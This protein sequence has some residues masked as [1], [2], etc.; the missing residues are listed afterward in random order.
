[1][2]RI[3]LSIFEPP[4]RKLYSIVIN[5]LK[6]LLENSYLKIAIINCMI[7]PFLLAI[8]VELLELIIGNLIFFHIISSQCVN[9]NKMYQMI[10]GVWKN[11]LYYHME[12][13]ILKMNK[14]CAEVQGWQEQSG[15]ESRIMQR[16]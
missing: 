1:M 15:S 11:C 2:L 5:G 13:S 6:L 14:S 16:L 8:K 4:Y 3:V 9:Q 7:H 12:S 10:A